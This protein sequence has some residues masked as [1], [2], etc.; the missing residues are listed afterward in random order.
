[1][2]IELSKCLNNSEFYSIKLP[3]SKSQSNRALLIKAL[4]NEIIS[5]KNLSNSDDTRILDEAIHS[6]NSVIDVGHGGTTLRFLTAFYSIQNKTVTLTGSERIKQRPILPLI[7]ALE[8]LGVR[9]IF[10]EKHGFVPFKIVG[11][12]HITQSSVH[13]DSNI[14]SQFVS[15]LMMIGPMLQNGIDINF[16]NNPVSF[17]FIQLTKFMMEIAGAE[18]QIEKNSIHIKPKRYR[19]TFFEIEADYA[20]ASYWY[21]FVFLHP[22]EIKLQLNGLKQNSAQPDSKVV[23]IFNSL[24]VST[25]FNEAGALI[26]KLKDFQK[27]KF[28]QYNFSDCPDLV[29]TLACVCAA[30]NIESEFDGLITLNLKESK[31]LE[32]LKSELENFGKSIEIIEDKKLIIR[33]EFNMQKSCRIKTYNDH[34]IA[35]SF[36]SLCLLGTI[37]IEDASVVK[38]SYPE[39]WKEYEKLVEVNYIK[40]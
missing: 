23:E 35:M 8:Q 6:N 2:D 10:L 34:R 11:N 22:D 21:S 16:I 30:S 25:E 24:G 39:F 37:I 32:V 5:I 13:I 36:A 1:M 27:P 14:S 15:A 28:F 9:F 19:E 3:F 12:P 29:M 40:E 38:K 17:D 4:S 7:E 26:S 18:T 31:R 20:S 33:G